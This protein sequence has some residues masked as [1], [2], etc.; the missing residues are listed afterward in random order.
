MGVSVS[1]QTDLVENEYLQ[2]FVGKVHIPITDEQFWTHFL[3]YQI[4]L[5]DTRF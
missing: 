4:S 2:R 5:P 1:H 3:Q